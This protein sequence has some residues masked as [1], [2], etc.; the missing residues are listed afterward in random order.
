MDTSKNR[1][2][3]NQLLIFGIA[4]FAGI[5]NDM[6]REFEKALEQMQSLTLA[7]K[8]V[9][10]FIELSGYSHSQLCRLTKKYFDETP[11]EYVNQIKMKYAY[12]LILDT[13]IDYETICEM[14]GFESFS[15]FCKLFKKR[16]GSSPAA[17]RK[18]NV[19]GTKTI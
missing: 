16:Y 6:P 19:C 15:Y 2:L 17:F 10:A 14:V 12:K 8:G 5:K 7:A 18:E 3:V 9:T 4:G 11:T 1:I 13:K